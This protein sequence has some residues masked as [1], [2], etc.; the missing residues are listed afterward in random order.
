MVNG[1]SVIVN[2]FSKRIM[3]DMKKIVTISNVDKKI[4]IRIKADPIYFRMTAYLITVVMHLI[5]SM[6]ML[7]GFRGDIM[8]D[9]HV[10]S[11][12]I[13]QYRLISC[14]T[15]VMQMIYA[16]IGL[17][18]D[19]KTLNI[20][21]KNEVKT[22]DLWK[23]I[24]EILFSAI[25]FPFTFMV[26]TLFWSLYLFDR[27]LILPLS[28]SRVISSLS[29][30]IVHTA[31][32]PVALWEVIFLPRRPPKTHS[33]YLSLTA[34]FTSVYLGILALSYYEKGYWPYPILNVLQGTIYI[35][36]FITV[37]VALLPFYYYLQWYP[38]NLVWGRK[39]YDSV[40]CE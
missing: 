35:Q 17:Y 7:M 30:H 15:F 24:R 29:N 5:N 37:V 38:T 25:V 18:C 8:N 14:W 40:K 19:Y 34:L 20:K 39:K 1:M 6:V 23:T 31:I 10:K 36:I 27:N 16:A 12:Y 11:Y 2:T 13:F 26:S 9:P 33:S 22:L 21:D 4:F 28:M 3:M 32:I